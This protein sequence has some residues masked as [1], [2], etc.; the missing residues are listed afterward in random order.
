M[1]THTNGRKGSRSKLHTTQDQQK[2]KWQWWVREKIDMLW[3]MEKKRQCIL[4]PF[5]TPFFFSFSQNWY[6]IDFAVAVRQIQQICVSNPTI[7]FSFIIYLSL[8]IF[9]VRCSL[10]KILRTERKKKKLTTPFNRY[11]S[12]KRFP[13]FELGTGVSIESSSL[14]FSFSSEDDD[15]IIVFRLFIFV[16]FY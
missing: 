16:V 10:K 12:S 14:S 13:L 1:V 3:R 4:F 6:G 7:S 11:N 15:I 5:P 2:Q 9:I 8:I